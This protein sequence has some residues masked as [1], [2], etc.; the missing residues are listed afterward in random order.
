LQAFG[1]FI[2]SLSA[3]VTN[4]KGMRAHVDV[5][6]CLFDFWRVIGHAFATRTVRRMMGVRLSGGCVRTVLSI[7]LVAGYVVA[8]AG[9]DVF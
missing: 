6:D 7:G 5:R 2:A 1:I 8:G 3:G 9:L 4:L